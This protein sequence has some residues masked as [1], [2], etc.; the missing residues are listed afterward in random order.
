MRG[1]DEIPDQQIAVPAD[2]PVVDGRLYAPPLT[3][4]P[5]PVTT[6]WQWLRDGRPI[7]GADRATYKPRA[8]DRGH[9]VSVRITTSRR[10]YRDGVYESDARRIGWGRRPQAT[11][12]PSFVTPALPGGVVRVSRGH[13]T[14]RPTDYTFTWSSDGR[15]LGHRRSLRVPRG[16][17]GRLL[18]LEVVAHR[19]GHRDGRATVRTRV[20]RG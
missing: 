16:L 20:F 3:W 10:F 13:W 14:Q 15:V 12:R 7:D 2:D 11:A 18:T 5:T 17:A 4:W 6:A 8:G 19:A 9:A 1:P